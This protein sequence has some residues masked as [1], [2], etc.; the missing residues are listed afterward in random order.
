MEGCPIRLEAQ[1]VSDSGGRGGSRLFAGEEMKKPGKH[2]IPL[3]C[4]I[5]KVQVGY[6]NPYKIGRPASV[7][8]SS[9]LL[10]HGP[11]LDEAC[12]C[13]GYKWLNQKLN[14]WAVFMGIH[15]QGLT[16]NRGSFKFCPYCGK[17]VTVKEET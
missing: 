11:E 6:Y 4:D 1:D 15:S 8:C 3:S 14:S 5:C 12:D 9:H 10:K 17:R 16:E 2:W 7:R 13:N